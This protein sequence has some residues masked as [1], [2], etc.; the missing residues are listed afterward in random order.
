MKQV[1]EATAVLIVDASGKLKNIVT[2]YDT[3]SYLREQAE[4]MLIVEDIETTIKAF[5]VAAVLT[6]KSWTRKW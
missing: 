6:P 4:D 3:T 1:L 5:I 2:T